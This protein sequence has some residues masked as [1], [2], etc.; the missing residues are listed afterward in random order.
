[1][2][3]H[4]LQ[5]LIC[6]KIRDDK[7]KS[8]H[9]AFGIGSNIT[10]TDIAKVAIYRIVHRF[11]YFRLTAAVQ[12]AHKHPGKVLMP[13]LIIANFLRKIFVA[14]TLHEIHIGLILID[15]AEGIHRISLLTNSQ[16]HGTDIVLPLLKR[17]QWRY[18]Q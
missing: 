2:K 6:G 13:Q 9:L 5:L 3:I 14:R 18:A 16:R 7:G 11:L 10:A 1:M 12:Q 17:E 15:I 4:R 8:I